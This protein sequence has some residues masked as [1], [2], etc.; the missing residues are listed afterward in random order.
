MCDTCMTHVHLARH[1]CII[2]SYRWMKHFIHLEDAQDLI[3]IQ[4]IRYCWPL[5]A[6]VLATNSQLDTSKV[7]K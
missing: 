7:L 1:I 5:P 6:S 4:C 3:T 2:V